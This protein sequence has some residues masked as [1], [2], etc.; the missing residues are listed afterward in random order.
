MHGGDRIETSKRTNFELETMQNYSRSLSDCPSIWKYFFRY[1]LAQ[2]RAKAKSI[3]YLPLQACPE[4]KE[5]YLEAIESFPE[6]WHELTDLLVEK[7]LR[8]RT[9]V[10]EVNLFAETMAEK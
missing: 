6:L 8:L 9:M 7:Q 3:V 5:L 2:S 4:V 10:E 1:E